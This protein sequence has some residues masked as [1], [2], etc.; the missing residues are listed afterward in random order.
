MELLEFVQQ[1]IRLTPTMEKELDQAFVREVLPKNHQLVKA[2]QFSQ[3]IFFI[4]KGS[5]RSYYFKDG[6]DITHYFFW[7]NSFT[8][9]IES[10][11][12]NQPSPFGVELLE[13][14]TI[15]SIQY[16]VLE[17]YLNQSSEL[18]KLMRMLLID[19]LKQLSN[20]FF[21]L[22]FQSAQERYNA[23]VTKQPEI[24]QRVS[25]GHLASYLGITQQTLSVIR[26]QK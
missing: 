14:G 19:I 4:E 6:K 7:E 8:L 25:L 18:E 5:A 26:A 21:E 17:N 22:Q 3:K 20:R 1:N 15:R 9:P 10:I 23:I 13:A 11:F 12:Y 16:S 24:L 2:G